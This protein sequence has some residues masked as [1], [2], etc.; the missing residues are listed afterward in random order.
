[1][2]ASFDYL[3][4][5]TDNYQYYI[6]AGSV[7]TILTDAFATPEI[8]HPFYDEVSAQ[9]VK[10]SDWLARFANAK[11]FQDKSVAYEE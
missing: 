3:S 6:G 9:G 1:M 11:K 2:T 7:H 10:F 4:S 8:P 5:T